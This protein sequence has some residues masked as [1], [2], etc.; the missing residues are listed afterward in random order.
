[1][2]VFTTVSSVILAVGLSLSVGA[3]LW[4]ALGSAA[5]LPLIFTVVSFALARTGEKPCY[6]FANARFA[7]QAVLSEALHFSRAI[8]TMSWNPR[9]FRSPLQ[10]TSLARPARPVLLV[11][12]ILCNRAVW[13]PL[14]ARLRAAGF[15]P[16][17][18]VSLE[19]LFADID[20]QAQSLAPELLALHQNSHG[21][22][23]A[24]VSHSMGGLVTRSLLRSV[25]SEMI[26]RVITIA[27]PHHGTRLVRSL[28]WPATR[29]M[30]CESPWLQALGTSEGG[31]FPVPFT[32][33]YSL[34]DNLIAPAA[35]ARLTGAQLYP[36][37]GI[38]HLGMLS[39]RAALDCVMAVLCQPPAA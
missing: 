2:L 3:T 31:H 8:L 20:A 30:D 37:R 27:C 36:M 1:M 22:R 32:S 17:N 11:H 26:N 18:A 6:S 14:A 16:V 24:I 35:S 23:V 15:G 5:A 4:I 39:T 10:A 34:E 33:I 21:A 12:G 28:P 19:P 25:G 13:R 29:Q 9:E 38:G 7:V